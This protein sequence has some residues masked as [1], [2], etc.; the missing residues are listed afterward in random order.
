MKADYRTRWNRFNQ[1]MAEPSLVHQ[2]EAGVIFGGLLL[3]VVLLLLTVIDGV[4]IAIK[5][6]KEVP[7]LLRAVQALARVDRAGHVVGGSEAAEALRTEKSA[8]VS[9]QAAKGEQAATTWSFQ[10][11]QTGRL[12]PGLSVTLPS[13]NRQ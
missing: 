3:D 5:L 13:L 7:E 9:T 11:K 2:F 1:L 4:G 6:A 10:P 8:V 12:E